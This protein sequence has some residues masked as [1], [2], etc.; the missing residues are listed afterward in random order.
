M[1]TVES[2]TSDEWDSSIDWSALAECAV[3]AA[4][5]ASASAEL[6]EAPLPIEVSIRFT[7]DEKVRSLNASYRG[8]D[9]PTNVL[10][11]PM[12]E[13][14]L[15]D[16]IAS[17]GEGELLLGDLVLAHGVCAGEAAE[18]S[19]PVEHHAAHLVVHGT[20][21]LLGYDHERG[22]AEAEAMETVE[23]RALAAIGISDPYAVTEVKTQ[24]HV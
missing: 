11:F 2:D 4:V 13:P 9:K 5:A 1:I 14:K 23:R 18:K 7:S 12:V 8:K 3:L 22:D 15:I 20:L 16:A 21:H 19:I 17:G 24:H 6:I 10:S